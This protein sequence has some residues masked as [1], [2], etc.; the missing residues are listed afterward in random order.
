LRS[1]FSSLFDLFFLFSRLSVTFLI[2]VSQR[3]DL[4]CTPFSS[5]IGIGNSPSP[6]LFF[7]RRF[8]PCASTY[9]VG[10]FSGL[11]ADVVFL[12]FLGLVMESLTPVFFIMVEM[13]CPVP[14]SRFFFSFFIYRLLPSPPPQSSAFANALWH[15][16]NDLS[17]DNMKFFFPRSHQVL[18]HKKTI[19]DPSFLSGLC[20]V[21]SDLLHPLL[22]PQDNSPFVESSPPLSFPLNH[23]LFRCG[24]R[25]QFR[26]FPRTFR[27]SPS[28]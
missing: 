19:L 6:L 17:P 5:F 28:S 7:F 11:F 26:G 23:L 15:C 24:F 22:R 9:W 8:P 20:F 10:F 13:G 21:P 14:P 4:A 2:L 12:H 18:G 25:R 27:A 1:F 16:I 3:R